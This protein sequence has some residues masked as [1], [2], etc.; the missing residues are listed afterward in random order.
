MLFILIL[1]TNDDAYRGY[2]AWLA[3]DS[4]SF[5]SYKKQLM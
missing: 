3:L 1:K 4:V 2:A 5:N